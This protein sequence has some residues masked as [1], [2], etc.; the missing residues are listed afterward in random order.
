MLL[1]WQLLSMVVGRSSVPAPLVTFEALREAAAQGLLWPHFS[2][3]MGRVVS[4]F[5]LAMAIGVVVGTVMGL[6]KRSEQLLDLPIM[7]M[8]T[9]PSLCYII[10][11]FMWFGIN[12]RSAVI[13]ITLT[14]VPAVAINMWSGVKAVDHRLTDM[15]RSF[16]TT[17]LRKTAFVVLPQVLPYTVAAMRY[18]LGLVWKV[19]VLVE[20]LGRP[21]GVGYMLNYSFQIFDMPSVFAWT[22]FFIFI[23]LAIELLL[24]KPA[25]NRLFRWRPQTS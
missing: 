25:E 15:A 23:M 19:T 11:A 1:A 17:R 21:D 5:V 7:V 22:L 10:V 16:H 12:E 4:S 2:A 20:L 6:S 8:L 18:G 13:A 9:I 3:T 14:T 24:L